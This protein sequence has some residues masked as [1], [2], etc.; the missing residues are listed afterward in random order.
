MKNMK[1]ILSVVTALLLI[2]AFNSCKKSGYEG[3]SIERL[4]ETN[5]P[6]YQSIDFTYDN[7]GRIT[8]AVFTDSSVQTRTEFV[9]YQDSLTRKRY[10]AQGQITATAVFLLNGDYASSGTETFTTGEMRY[11]TFA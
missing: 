8:K 10:N 11:Y 1:T 3:C 4:N 6:G 7:E 2:A 9:Y 5:N